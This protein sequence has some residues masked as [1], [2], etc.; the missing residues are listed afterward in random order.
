MVRYLKFLASG[1]GGALALFL[2]A[3][4][5]A[6]QSAA[7]PES[8]GHVSSPPSAQVDGTA[9]TAAARTLAPYLVRNLDGTLRLEAP[10]TVVNSLPSKY[11]QE[12]TAG[13]GVLNAKVASGELQ[14][15]GGG[16]V[17]D[18]RSDT[19]MLQGGWSGHGIAWWGQYW[20]LSH[21]D[22]VYMNAGWWWDIS[23]AGIGVIAYLSGGV[24]A[25]LGI[26]YVYKAWM[27]AADHGNGSCLNYSWVGGPMWVTSQ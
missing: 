3:V 10:S 12:L 22:I 17:F 16:A 7:T 11:V 6:A 24:G 4:P 26:I 27:T 20:C 8:A 1:A 2:L 19:L 21:N 5:A 25:A 13:L 14:T 18:P 15:T 23:A 9:L